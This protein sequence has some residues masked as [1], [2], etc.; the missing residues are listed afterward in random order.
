MKAKTQGQRQISVEQTTA[1]STSTLRLW[2][3]SLTSVDRHLPQWAR[4]S[5]PIVRRHLGIYWKI[6]PLEVDLLLRIYGLQVG[7]IMLS[8]IM[9]V[10][11]PIL[12]TLLPVSIVMLPFVAAAYVRVLAQVGMFT[13]RMIVD[14]QNNNTLALLRTTPIPLR[15]I[16]FSKAA[17]GVWRQIEDLSLL[18]MGAALL[19]LPVIGLQHAAYWPLDQELIVSRLSLIIVLGASVLRMMIE[20]FMIA[21]LAIVIGSVVPSRIPAMTALGA[22]GFFYFLFINLPRVLDMPAEMRLLLE[23]VLPLALPLIIIWASFRAAHYILTRD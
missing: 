3:P 13:T 12:F 9:P 18:L 6:L 10:V 17:A 16:L 11:L 8:M 20:P 19:S 7:L 14:E 2:Q 4:R 15:H 22:T 21:A 5:D 23:G 1:T